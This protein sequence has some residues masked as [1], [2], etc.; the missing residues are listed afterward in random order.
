MTDYSDHRVVECINTELVNTLGN[1]L[2]RC[3]STA[4]NPNQVFPKFEFDVFD[5][6]AT[7]ECKEMM[8]HLRELPGEFIS[9][10]LCTFIIYVCVL[11]KITTA[12][13]CIFYHTL[14]GP[15]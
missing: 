3:T 5:E 10:F 6:K 14:L 13:K 8:G 4:L 9:A 11:D 7:S 1:L 12:Y 15:F 2:S